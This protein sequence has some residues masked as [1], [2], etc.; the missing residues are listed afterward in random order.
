MIYT[1]AE[2]IKNLIIDSF[3]KMFLKI[4]IINN[5]DKNETIERGRRKENYIARYFI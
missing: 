1:I 2:Y 5:A 4:R 3:K